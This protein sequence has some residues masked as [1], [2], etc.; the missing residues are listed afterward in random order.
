ML[1]EADQRAL[2]RAI[3]EVGVAAAQAEAGLPGQLPLDRP[4]GRTA[5]LALGKAAG[6]MAR[7]ALD[8]LPVDEALI[9]TRR[10]HMPA[11]W[12][13]PACAQVIQAGHPNPDAASLLAGETAVALAESLGPGDRLIALISGGGSALMAA[14][15]Q[16]I[17]FPEK[18][19]IYRALLASGAPIA[20][21][22]QV[23]A[24]L[25]RVKGGRLAAL[26]Y[27]AQ[28]V[29]FV[30][31]DV[32]G[33][34]AALV[35]SGPTCALPDGD[36]PISILARWGIAVPDRV[37]E[38]MRRD[39]PALRKSDQA[40][41]VARPADALAA[42]ARRAAA[43][44]FRP[45]LLGDAIEGDAVA[46]AQA[47]ASLAIAFHDASQR[48]AIISGGEASVQ[49][50]A[51]SGIGGRNLA[52]ALALAIALDGRAGIFAVAAD[53]DGIDGTSDAAG[54]MIFPTTLH[55]AVERQLCPAQCLRDQNSAD[56][57]A[58]LGD[59]LVTGPTGTN[60]NDLRALLVDPA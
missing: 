39:R 30:M 42:M 24:A 12:A 5:L 54:A 37:A 31:S 45:V 13:P 22:N 7:V 6:Q 27:P 15:V 17:S 9:I 36:D 20:D 28:V 40:V 50:T 52:Y 29:T 8:R 44:G 43:A 55:R 59:T 16:G 60:V 58:R 56:L 35:A 33:D 11:G 47:H 53:S 21:M 4:P 34:N 26:A 48:V 23:R 41:V 38:I 14:P 1:I 49:V 19:A 32:P 51:P 57:F 46:I 10:G 2:L 25:S 3:F 18:Q